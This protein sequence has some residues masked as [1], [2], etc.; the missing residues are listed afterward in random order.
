MENKQPQ[1]D[2]VLDVEVSRVVDGL[3][4]GEGSIS[5][6]DRVEEVGLE[7]LQQVERLITSPGILVP[8][9]TDKSGTPIEDDGCG[10]GRPVGR[11]FMGLTEKAH[12]LNRSKVFG[13]GASM[14][15][16]SLIATGKAADQTIR[17][18]FTEGIKYLKDR[19]L[20][21]GAH[22]D[23]HAHG[24]NCGCGAIDKAPMII[25]DALKFEQG[26][27]GVIDVLS[28]QNQYID[29]VYDNFRDFAP[30]MS[31]ETY[32]GSSVAI[33]IADNGKVIK[34][35]TGSHLEMYIIL[36]TVEGHTVDQEKVRAASGGAVQV[37]AVD[38]WRMK[39]LADKQYDNPVDQE[40]A[41]IGELIYTLATAGTLTK[42]DL[43]VYM[44]S[45]RP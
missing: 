44:I 45:K 35:L 9:D 38:V 10:D 5:H 21:F 42:G 41:F 6:T 2:V 11:V 1:G 28:P 34:E 37:F 30:T 39:Q 33:E 7:L 17:D 43:P 24:S 36:N 26:I 14:A 13:G 32:E 3:G 40:K 23:D 16:A 27:R 18:T 8:I 25:G 4:F 19:Q 29:P 20:G 15:V 31:P 22:T 12:S